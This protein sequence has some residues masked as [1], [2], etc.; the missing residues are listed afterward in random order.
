MMSTYAAK[1]GIA[2]YTKYLCEALDQ[3][4]VYS[5]VLAEY[6]YPSSAKDATWTSK[7]PYIFNWLRDQPYINL[8]TKLYPF[9]EDIKDVDIVHIQHQFG[10]FP[11]YR[12]T[13]NLYQ[14]L[15]NNG[16]KVVTTLHDVVPPNSQ[17]SEY[18]KAIFDHSD[19]IVVHTKT[20]EMY[21]KQW[22][23]DNDK[24]VLIPHGTLLVDIPDKQKTRKE[25]KIPLDAEVVM[26]W[27]FIWESKGL[28][29]LLI[30]FSELLKT[31]PNAMFIH[32]GGVH[33]IIQGS[34]YLHKMIR[35]AVKYGLTPQNFQ[36]TQWVPED[37]VPTWFS[38]ADLI[39]LNYMRGS[40]SASGAAHRAL[41]SHRP[42]VKTDDPCLEEIPAHQVARFDLA[43][44]LKG[45]KEVLENPELQK[46]LVEKQDKASLEMSWD[47]VAKQHKALYES[48]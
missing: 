26:S 33:P 47:A 21:L 45:I 22:N 42:I 25:L 37:K 8:D 29:D 13:A 17:M 6:P 15:K 2:T 4:E 5:K 12:N 19:K 7:V 34:E 18:F 11:Q 14:Y 3:N 27:G 43:D 40:A 28:T 46:E 20:C 44:M 24:I 35:D 9:T 31:H 1:C 10:L 36:I 48:L 30:V 41:A 39:V 32:A 23:I 16:K 38:V